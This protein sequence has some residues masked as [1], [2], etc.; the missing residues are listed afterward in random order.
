[1][2]KLPPVKPIDPSKPLVVSFY[3]KTFCQYHHQPIYHHQPSHDIE[4]CYR[5][6][7]VV[8]DLI[9]SNTTIVEGVNDIGNKS[10]SPPNQNL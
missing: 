2:I 3:P 9:D 4:K 5:M 1:M 8:Q 6:K 7:H 10:V